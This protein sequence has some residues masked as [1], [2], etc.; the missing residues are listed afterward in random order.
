M[1]FVKSVKNVFIVSF[2]LLFSNIFSNPALADIYTD[3]KIPNNMKCVFEKVVDEPSVFGS[4]PGFKRDSRQNRI[5]KL[6]RFYKAN[7]C[8]YNKYLD[9]FNIWGLDIKDFRK[10][11]DFISGNCAN[12][13]RKSVNICDNKFD[14]NKIIESYDKKYVPKIN[15]LLN[16]DKTVYPENLQKN[17]KNAILSLEN[18][19]Y[20]CKPVYGAQ[21][22]GIYFLQKNT[23]GVI[24]SNV[25]GSQIEL[26]SFL[27][28]IK[29]GNYIVQEYVY[30]HP[31]LAVFNPDSLNTL[32]VISIKF[33]KKAN[34]LAAMLRIG[35][36][37]SAVDNA[38][39]GGICVGINLKDGTLMKYGVSY[40]KAELVHKES[41]I[42]YEG[43]KIP[44][45]STV[46]SLITELHE[47]KFNKSPSVGFD[48]AITK[49]GPKLIEANSGWG[50]L[51]LQASSGGIKKRL[52]Y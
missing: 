33:N 45:W 37:G 48:V 50:T 2:L 32:R 25:H 28:K 14:F 23:S 51:G 41:G 4:I 40:K 31:D 24:V 29:N 36:K 19:K 10:P 21:G 3:N 7:D 18:G 9:N 38:H 35:K 42:K 15:L 16:K 11:E 13:Y 46:K 26:D 6:I 17:S 44:H 43:Y 34:I 8:N 30:Q 12:K 52:E 5:K 47:T 49:E 1:L 27:K 22:N 39:K 20:V